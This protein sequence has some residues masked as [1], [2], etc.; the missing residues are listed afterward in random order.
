MA[1]AVGNVM[2]NSRRSLLR[3]QV[4]RNVFFNFLVRASVIVLPLTICFDTC[5]QVF[6][7]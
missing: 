7:F 1:E 6:R 5:E 3:V 2:P 4:L